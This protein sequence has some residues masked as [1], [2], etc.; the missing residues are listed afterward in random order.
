MATTHWHLQ[1]FAIDYTPS[2][3]LP[4]QR[5][6]QRRKGLS[7]RTSCSCVRNLVWILL[8]AFLA[9][10]LSLAAISTRTQKL[11]FDENYYFPVAEKIVEGS[12]EDGYVIRPP[13]YPLFLA[14]LMALV[15]KSF[16][17]ILVAQSITRGITVALTGLI[18]KKI[19]DKRS[20]FIASLL[21]AIYPLHIYTYNRFLTEVI[22]V[23]LFLLSLVA[24]DK[25]LSVKRRK[26][27][28]IAGVASGIASLARSTSFFLTIL[29][30]VWSV[31][32]KGEGRRAS[33]V[34]VTNA[35]VLLLG[36]FVVIS[37]WTIRNAVTHR[38]FILLD[39]A[40]PF[41]LWLI[42][43]GKDID[44]FAKIWSSYPTHAERQREAYKNWIAN[45]KEDPFFHLK[46][47]PRV[48][49]KIY[50]PKNDPSI[51]SLSTRYKG[52]TSI[53]NETLKRFLEKLV[54]TWLT[55]VTAGGIAGL[56]IFENN[57]SRKY[58]FLIVVIYF[59]LLHGATLARPRFMLPMNNLLAIYAAAFISKGVSRL[60]L[61]N[62][63]FRCLS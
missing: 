46:R 19:F 33:S 34:A 13:L 51:N 23:P 41:N 58:L 47:M 35:L 44:E 9:I 30:G 39:N 50:N 48:I 3:D 31:L 10:G 43:S 15:S 8:P 40:T 62:Q 57:N 25:A 32:R 14:A 53:P 11:V 1:A 37:P 52:H 49:S 21:I 6:L 2:Q 56:L 61:T 54:P 26:D 7:M 28:L 16:T 38:C 55:I 29:I 60:G 63:S 22:Y 24:V 59:V 17:A 27:F 5:W 20:A 36:M 4:S 12:Y 42:T 18:A 45:V